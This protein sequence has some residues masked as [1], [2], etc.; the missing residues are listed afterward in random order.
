VLLAIWLLVT[1]VI[2]AFLP[3][4]D[5]PIQRIGNF[6]AA[7]VFVG[8]A[9]IL[10]AILSIIG[11]RGELKAKSFNKADWALAD[12]IADSLERLWRTPAEAAY[13]KKDVLQSVTGAKL[14]EIERHF[15]QQTE[16]AI[17]GTM[18]HKLSMFGA[19]F[20]QSYG[21]AS[22][23]H[24]MRSS[25]FSGSSLTGFAASIKGLS[26]VDLGMSSTT[27]D[28]LMGDALF[29][30]FEAPGPAGERDTYR[31]ISMSQP[32]VQ[33]WINDLVAHAAQQFGGPQTHSGTT[34][35]VWAGN[36]M[37]QFQPQDISY[38]TDRLKAIS[39][40][41]YEDRE[42]VEIVGTPAGRNAMV[43]SRVRIG[44]GE[45]L[46]L[47]PT[48]FPALLGTAIADAVTKGERTL[49]PSSQR[50]AIGPSANAPAQAG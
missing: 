35:N 26:Q 45:Q 13:E 33:G 38:V 2:Y 17:V 27:R 5:D 30:V 4:K 31:V 32:G 43:A 46:N 1:A 3:G 20:S 48:A 18:S 8:W 39:T 24:A 7:Q 49:S 44:Q 37:M 23:N 28:N 16:G 25:S 50:P 36:L 42:P 40:R 34:V 11:I 14:I 6:G 21:S 9:F 15:D 41:P 22:H 47:M 29:S 12:A 19:A 10:G